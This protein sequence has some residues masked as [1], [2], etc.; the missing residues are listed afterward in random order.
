MGPTPNQQPEDD[1]GR[2]AGEAE[3]ERHAHQH[4]VEIELGAVAG[5]TDSRAQPLNS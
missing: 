1:A 5:S 4:L 2:R 3:R